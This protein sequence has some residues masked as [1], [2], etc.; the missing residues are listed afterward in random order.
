MT[1]EN[2]YELLKQYGQLHVLQ[3]YEELT[4]T[5]RQELLKQIAMLDFSVCALSG[6]KSEPAGKGR[7]SPLKAVRMEEIEVKRQE[8]ENT[9]LETLKAGKVA[10]VLLA[11][12]MGTRLGCEVPKGMCDIGLTKP[13]YIFQRLIENLLEVVEKAGAWVHL[14]IMTS[15]TNDEMTRAFLKEHDYFGYH[16]EYITFFV[17]EMMPATDRD[18]KVLL[19]DKGR[20]AMSPNGNGGWFASMENCGVLQMVYEKGIEWM[21]V[22]AV[23]NVLQKIADPCFVGATVRS[24]CAVGSKVVKKA[25]PEEKVGVMCLEDGKPSIVEYYELTEDMK[26]ETDEEGEPAYQFGVILNYLFRVEDLK[27]TIHKKMPVHVVEKKIPCLDAA[28][29]KVEPQQ[30]NGLKYETL[31][32]DM[33]HLSK[34]CLPFEVEREKEFAPIKNKEGVDSVDT[35]RILLQKNGVML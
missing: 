15:D 23:D 29:H 35:A 5:E 20:I 16:E 3:Y 34:D 22:F 14:F 27:E 28:G 24:G 7:F 33:I 2:A 19:E 12:G 1:Y 13:V 8:F 18:G 9:G 11:G 6:K 30:P 25:F 31:A 26:N 10:G 4:E 32:L 17:Q 21:N